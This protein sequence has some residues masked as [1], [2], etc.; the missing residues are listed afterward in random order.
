MKMLG[1]YKF[2][3]EEKKAIENAIGLFSWTSLA[4]SR[5]K[6]KK[7]KREKSTEW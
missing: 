4:E 2:T 5:V 1:R 6:R 7:A 3:P